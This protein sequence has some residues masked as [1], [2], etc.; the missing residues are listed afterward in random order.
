MYTH[1]MKKWKNKITHYIHHLLFPR[2]SNNH[3]SKVLHHD[4]LFFIVALFVFLGST[5]GVVQN[6]YP[7]VLGISSNITAQDLLAFTNQKRQENGL[8][9]LTLNAK[10]SQAAEQKASHM[11]AND[12]WAHVAPDGTTPWYFIKSAGYEYLY[13]G[14]NLARGFTTASAVVDAWMNSPTHRENM[15]SANYDDVG[16]AIQTGTL[17]G[18]ETIL[19]VQELGRQYGSSGQVATAETVQ[20]LEPTPVSQQGGP[21]P[22]VVAVTSVT[23]TQAILPTA[24]PTLTPSPTPTVQPISVAAVANQPLFD[25]KSLTKNI[26]LGILIFLVLVLIIDAVIIERRSIVRMVAHNADHILFIIIVILV[27]IVIGKGWIL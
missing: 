22:I 12:Y 11:F 9:P 26:S 19:V 25:S 16:F 17:T 10:L 6:N 8:G 2:E 21:T 5:V 13:A 24:T 20:A 3:R 7:Q 1:L 4:S 15:L 23:P 18:S 14:E 27:I